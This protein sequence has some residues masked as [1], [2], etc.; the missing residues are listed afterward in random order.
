MITEALSF[1]NLNYIYSNISSN[2]LRKDIAGYFGMHPKVFTSWLTVLVNIRNS[3]C[4]HARIWNRDFVIRATEPHNLSHK[5]IDSSRTDKARLY[6]RV[7]IVKYFLDVVSP[8][9][10]LSGKLSDLFNKFPQIDLSAMG[11]P[12]GWKDE[13]MWH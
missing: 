3:V 2:R 4:H 9:N 7:C 1:G 6:Y 12:D 11:F 10:D 8:H 5:W 13:P